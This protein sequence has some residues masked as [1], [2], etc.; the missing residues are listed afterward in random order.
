MTPD[1]VYVGYTPGYTN[2]YV[3]NSSIH[4]GTGYTYPGWYGN[5]YY[6][7][8][9][10]WGFGVRWN[11]WT[12]WGFGFSYSY[13]PFTF[14]I[15]GG[16]WYRGGWWGPSRYNDY[17]HGY[18]RGYR[19]GY[20]AGYRGSELRE[21]RRDLYNN[22]GDARVAVDRRAN[23]ANAR[24]DRPNNVYTDRR[25]DVY[26]STDRGWQARS[27]GSWQQAAGNRTESLNQSS[28]ARARGAQRYGAFRGG[29]RG[30]ARRGP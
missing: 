19:R 8:P 3:Y 11:P 10:T 1:Y 20:Y 5:Y 17:R 13:G 30:G 9:A 21:R 29:G 24:V 6:P 23:L 28:H 22:Y 26:R 2:T 27:S 14:G 18:R 7:R 25:G 15:G 16:S 12:G 4:Y